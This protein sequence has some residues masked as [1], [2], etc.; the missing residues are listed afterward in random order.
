M[1]PMQCPLCAFVC[2][3]LLFSMFAAHFFLSPQQ[4]HL[5]AAA[6]FLFH[7]F[8]GLNGTSWLSRRFHCP[9]LEHKIIVCI[10]MITTI[11]LTARGEGT[12]CIDDVDRVYLHLVR[13]D[14]YHDYYRGIHRRA[15]YFGT[16]SVLFV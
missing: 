11:I 7:C 13:R 9:S 12:R 15:G 14:P 3:F 8:H 2:S 5:P 6:L 16:N 4:C 1:P 10:L